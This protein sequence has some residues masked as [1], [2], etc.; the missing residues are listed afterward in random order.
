MIGYS[1]NASKAIRH[2]TVDALF[3][4]ISRSLG[5]ES[6]F[7]AS[8]KLGTEIEIIGAAKL[9]FPSDNN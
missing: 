5:I 9:L 3:R 6:D 4:L 7:T 2:K 8:G 1:L